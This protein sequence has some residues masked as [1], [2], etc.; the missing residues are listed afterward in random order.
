MFT[1]EFLLIFCVL[2]NEEAANIWKNMNISSNVR[3]IVIEECKVY[4]QVCIDNFV[5]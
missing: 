5:Y 3:L 1:I 4:Y 2:R